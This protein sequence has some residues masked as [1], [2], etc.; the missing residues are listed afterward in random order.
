MGTS[1]LYKGP[2][3]QSLLPEGYEESTDLDNNPNDDDSSDAEDTSQKNQEEDVYQRKKQQ[4]QDGVGNWSTAKKAITK[5][6]GGGRTSISRAVSSYTKA[7]GG[8][9]GAAKKSKVA[10][11]ITIGLYDLFSGS[12]TQVRENLQNIGIKL[13]GRS[14]RD[15]FNEICKH[16]APTPDDLDNSIANKA[17]NE[18]I[19][20]IVSEEGFDTSNLDVFNSEMLNKMV[21]GFI[22]NYIFEKLIHQTGY[23]MLIKGKS[24]QEIESTE[25]NLKD[26]IGSIVRHVVKKNL[27]EGVSKS[28]VKKMINNL[29]ETSYGV[30]E[31]MA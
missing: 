30:M 13:E 4:N 11:S 20:E 29:Y 16:L 27:H 24:P 19:C 8:A 9:K 6:S 2:K 14:N 28:D 26:Y 7:L 12:S 5:T 21:S 17:L 1:N 18:T 22:T 10:Q 31:S 3:G 25:E 15:I 23:G